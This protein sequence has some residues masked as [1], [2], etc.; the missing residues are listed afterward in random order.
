MHGHVGTTALSSYQ[1]LFQEIEKIEPNERYFEQ[2][3]RQISIPSISISGDTVKLVA[4]EGDKGVNPLI[5]NVEEGSERHTRLKSNEIL[6]TRTQA[7]FDCNTRKA[8]VEYNQ[9]GAK[10]SDFAAMLMAFGSRVMDEKDFAFDLVPIPGAS[11]LEELRKFGRVQLASIHLVRPNTN[12]N[13][14]EDALSKLAH[15]SDART[16]EITMTAQRQGTLGFRHGILASIRHLLTRS[17]PNIKNVRVQGFHEDSVAKT[18]LSLLNHCEQKRVK[19]RR[20]PDGY[21]RPDEVAQFLEKYLNELIAAK[22][23]DD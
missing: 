14:A 17:H 22:V 21:P 16:F 8:V 9:R 13:D 2:G 6:A 19:V 12:W 23:A 3:E 4:Y 18:A 20:G 10:A 1:N 5:F 15:E 11:F 7:I